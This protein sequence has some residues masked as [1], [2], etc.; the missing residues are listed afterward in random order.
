MS[1]YIADRET[2]EAV[3]RGAFMR[4]EDGADIPAGAALLAEVNTDNP[5]GLFEALYAMNVAAFCH[6]YPSPSGDGTRYP[7]ALVRPSVRL[8]DQHRLL[9]FDRR[10]ARVAHAATATLLYQCVEGPVARSALY[11]A[12]QDLSIRLARIAFKIP[13]PPHEERELRSFA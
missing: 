1:C 11:A 10:Q 5:A 13:A 4:E 2:F 3:C 7:D 8:S 12:L 6:R 9:D